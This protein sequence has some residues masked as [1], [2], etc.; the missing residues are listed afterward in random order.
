[1]VD[2]SIAIVNETKSA[3]DAFCSSTRD[4]ISESSERIQK[5]SENEYLNDVSTGRTPKSK[6]Y[7]NNVSLER[8]MPHPLLIENYRNLNQLEKPSENVIILNF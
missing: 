6:T 7:V 1:M 4:F 5:F 2:S 8:T 3:C